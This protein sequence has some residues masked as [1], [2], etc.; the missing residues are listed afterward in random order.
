MPGEL[1]DEQTQQGVGYYEHLYRPTGEWLDPS[2]GNAWDAEKPKGQSQM[3]RI[4]KRLKKKN[5]NIK[6]H[7]PE[8]D[9]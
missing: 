5:K 4:M 1:G 6:Y 7:I 8:K 2:Y 3:D 9:I